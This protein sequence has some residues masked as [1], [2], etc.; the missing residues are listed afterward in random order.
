MAG[1]RFYLISCQWTVVL[2]ILFGGIS[3]SLGDQVAHWPLDEGTGEIFEN[4]VDPGFNGFLMGGSAIEWVGVA[5]NADGTG[6][7]QENAVH[8]TGANSWIQTNFPGIGGA[9]PRTIALWLNTTA[10]NTHGILGYGATTNGEKWHIRVNNNAGNG[11][12]NAIRTE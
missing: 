6:P 10:T 1:K 4:K 8:F 5:P 3:T 2:S 12:L 11:N 9:A 7:A